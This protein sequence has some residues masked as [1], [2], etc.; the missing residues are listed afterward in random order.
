MLATLEGTPAARAGV[1]WGDIVLEVN[2]VATRNWGDYI[3]AKDRRKDGMAVVLFRNGVVTTLDLVFD[4]Q[5]APFDV[6]RALEVIEK[7]NLAASADA[8][9]RNT[10]TPSS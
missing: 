1:R 7:T 2:G 4:A 9:P 10:G 6:V 3:E 5:P 8:P